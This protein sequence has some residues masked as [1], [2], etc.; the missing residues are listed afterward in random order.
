[1][2]EPRSPAVV[3]PL[4]VA[5]VSAALIRGRPAVR[6]AAARP[7][8]VLPKRGPGDPDR[9]L[10][11]RLQ[12]PITAAEEEALALVE[13]AR[14]EPLRA[15]D[16]IPMRGEDLLRQAK[17]VL[18]SLTDKAVAFVGDLDGTAV[19][20][21]LLAV[22]GAR[23]PSR[24]L[25]L[26]FDARVLAAALGLATRH[27]FADLLVVRRYNCFDP[28]PN[29]LVGEWDYFYVNPPYGSHNR[30]ESARLF[31][32]RGCELV[33]T[34]GGSGCLI[35]PDDPARP[36]TQRAMHAT[37]RFLAIQG[38]VVREKLDQIHRYHL[39]DDPE[40]PSS[41]VLVDRVAPTDSGIPP[42]PYA[43]RRVGFDEI[44]GFY[45]QDVLPPY[46][47]YIDREGKHDDDWTGLGE[48]GETLS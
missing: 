20:L 33:R 46:P 32:T 7:L 30:G 10:K 1:M 48:E 43:G 34:D 41:L 35:L 6:E 11:H 38:W 14:P 42:M 25:V 27:G 13:Q 45:G 5:P 2:A 37:Q 23:G 15:F 8:A 19:L 29:D 36:W 28:L 12:V 31:I 4:P 44:P 39:D 16:Q 40:L 17:L 26:D 3:S 22:R 47:R 24:M 21:G 9:L 18:P